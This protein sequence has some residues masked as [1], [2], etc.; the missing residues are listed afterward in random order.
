[1]NIAVIGTGLAGLSA[2]L[3][4]ARAG[5]PVTLVGPRPQGRDGRTSALLRSSL[6]FLETLGV[7]PGLGAEAAPLRAMRLVDHTGRLVRAPVTLFRAAELDLDSFGHNIPNDRLLEA[8]T[9]AVDAAGIE[10]HE[11]PAVD[12]D[13]ALDHVEIRLPGRM[14]HAALAVAAD[15]RASLTRAAADI[16]VERW[17]Y[18]QSALVTELAH[19]A[20]HQFTST[21]FHRAHG[22]FTL[23]PLPG[24]RRSSLVWVDRP[25]RIA[26]AMVLS[27]EDLSAAVTE[28]ANWFLGRMRVEASPRAYPLEGCLARRMASGRVALVGEAAHAFPPIGAQGLNLGMRDVATLADALS[29]EEEPLAALDRYDAARRADV[30]SRSLAVD[31]LNRSLIGAFL[32]FGTARAVGLTALKAFAPLRRLVMRQGLGALGTLPRAMREPSPAAMDEIEQ[33]GHRHD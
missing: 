28:E 26:E 1:M 8:L 33:H 17:S 24:E 7:W 21:E 5:W 13:V 19:D 32:P 2:A 9:N 11:E 15:G 4:L 22:P 31:L 16:P 10:W 27:S 14:V 23:V 6:R 18:P 25:E 30:V 12:I 20:P 29:Q 3:H